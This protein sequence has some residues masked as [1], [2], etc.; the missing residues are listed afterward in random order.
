MSVVPDEDPRAA[1]L[2][3][4]C[5]DLPEAERRHD[6]PHA[7]YLVRGRTFAYYLD[8][9]HGDGVI[10]VACRAPGGETDAFVAADPEHRYKPAYIGARGWVGFRVDVPGVDWEEI[11]ELVVAS[12]LAVA[13]KRL[14]EQVAPPR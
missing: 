1:H 12:Y 5:E 2:W 11:A 6:G 9:H 13:P 8:D 3:A 14:A 4:I 10:G 7:T